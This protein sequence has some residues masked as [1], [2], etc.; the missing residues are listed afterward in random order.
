MCVSELPV[1]CPS[2]QLLFIYIDFGLKNICCN[3]QFRAPPRIESS[4]TAEQHTAALPS[5]IM[6]RQ[7]STAIRREGV[8]GVGVGARHHLLGA[9]TPHAGPHWLKYLWICVLSLI[10]IP[11]GRDNYKWLHVYNRRDALL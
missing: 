4:V 11:M 3:A 2:S 1:P 7:R 6:L 9:N 10:F 5:K 8:Q